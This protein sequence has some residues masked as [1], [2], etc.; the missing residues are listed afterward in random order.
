MTVRER[1]SVGGSAIFVRGGTRHLNNDATTV[2]SVGPNS[3]LDRSARH[4]GK[5]SP[6]AGKSRRRS[7]LKPSVR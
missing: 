2:R 1:P 7:K 4:G 3:L 5:F 6:I